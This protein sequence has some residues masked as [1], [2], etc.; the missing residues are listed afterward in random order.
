VDE[1]NSVYD[2]ANTIC[3]IIY[4]MTSFV[5][6]AN[7]TYDHRWRNRGSR[8]GLATPLLLLGVLPPHFWISNFA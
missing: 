8:M 7:V 5:P 2:K 3:G 1:A 6:S 4:M